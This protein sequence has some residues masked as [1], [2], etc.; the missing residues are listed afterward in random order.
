M[1]PQFS[2]KHTQDSLI[3]PAKLLHH[4]R[5]YGRFPTL[6]PPQT[7]IFCYNGRFLTQVLEQ[8]AHQ[9]CDGCFSNLFFFKDNPSVAIGNFGVGAPA[10]I[11]KMEELISWGVK[12]FISIGLAGSLNK[13]LKIG[14]LILCD[15]AI[16]DEGTSHHYLPPSRYIHAPRRMT[17]RLQELFKQNQIPYLIGSTWTTDS[18]YRQ[19]AQEVAHYQ[20]EGVLSVDMEVSALFAVAHFHQVDLGAMLTISDIHTESSWKP[21]LE[22]ERPRQGLHQLLKIALAAAKE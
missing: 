13:K 4:R 18:L 2:E 14:D 16:R 1:L 17:N 9:P 20:Q 8:M 7:A 21:H 19:T 5:Q 10:I 3:T 6:S 11:A 12:Q 22:D 15:K